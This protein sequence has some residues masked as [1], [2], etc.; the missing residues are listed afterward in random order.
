VL[1]NNFLEVSA[2]RFPD[3]IALICKDKRL[4]FCEIENRSN[5][6]SNA[7]INIGLLKQ[8]RAAIF[9]DN[10]VESVISIFAVLKAGGVFL[11]VNPLVK[12]KKLE[13]ILNDCQVKIIITDSKHRKEVSAIISGCPYLESVIF[14][15]KDSDMEDTFQKMNKNIFTF[16]ELFKNFSSTRTNIRCIDIDLASLIYTSGST[17]V[18]KGVILT[19]LNMVSAANSIIEYLENTPEDII[20][21]V[22]P[23]S[24]DYGLYQVLMSFKFGGTIV[25]EK[26]FLYPYEVIDLLIKEKATGFPIVP[27]IAAI[28]LNLKNLEKYNFSSLRYITN[29]AQALPPQ[30][31]R[32]L[33]KVFP[34]AKIYSMYGLTE[35]KR[36]SFLPPEELNRRPTS[37]G[38]AM[39]NTEV[40]I[41]DKNGEKI[42]KPGEIGELVIRGANVMKGYW[43]L[44][45]ETAR[46][47][48]PGHIPGER[49]L[50][51]GDLFKIDEEGFLYFVSR[52]DD[53]IKT[54][55]ER[56]SPKEIENV[57]HDLDEINEAAVV[58]VPDDILGQA[59]KAFITL[60]KNSKLAEED[61]IKYCS[62]NM[63]NF[64]IPKYVE[65]RESLPKSPH[66]KVNKKLLANT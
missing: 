26:S 13:Y 61:I 16:S 32:Q 24:F 17:G 28:L 49:V 36:V 18:P 50:Y 47:L 42:N 64:M 23:L 43:N 22:L 52:K 60:K 20:L 37:V 41:V 31:I 62:R 63:E 25:L 38:K 10:S 8:E 11:V 7:L 3:K 45:E 6:L 53:I 58:G 34:I 33:Q 51:S 54:A 2:D 27:T 1:V 29:T 35:C 12:A 46:V 65:I 39:P 55:G 48:K 15:K 19:H 21:S 59:I 44:P 9:L 66:G 5:C 30:Y 56:V 4:T 14:I 40:Y 57:L